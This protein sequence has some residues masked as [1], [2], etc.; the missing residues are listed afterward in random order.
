MNTVSCSSPIL[1]GKS[2]TETALMPVVAALLP[3][4]SHDAP[5]FLVKYTESFVAVTM[6]L[7][8]VG[9]ISRS[10]SSCISLTKRFVLFSGTFSTFTGNPVVIGSKD[11]RSRLT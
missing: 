9:W 6:I 4:L 7:E 8:L 5:P 2:R 1:S 3:M 10:L 11:L